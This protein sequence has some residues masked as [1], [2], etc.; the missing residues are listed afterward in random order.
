MLLK[1]LK[2][3]FII[4]EI[5]NDKRIPKLGKGF[6]TA[7]RLN[8][9]NPLSYVTLVLIIIVGILMFG[10]IGVWKEFDNRNPFR[11]Y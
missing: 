5:S 2:N 6:T 3:L 9:L 7:I 11:W 1:L 10:F 8:P 4:Q